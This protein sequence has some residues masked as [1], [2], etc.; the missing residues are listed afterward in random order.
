MN[1]Q[2]FIDTYVA[3]WLAN[4]TSLRYEEAC[5]DGN[6]EA[7]EKQPTEDAYSLESKAWDAYQH[8]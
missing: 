1:R 2:Q 8:F 5:A 7:L 6:Y 3:S 4:Y